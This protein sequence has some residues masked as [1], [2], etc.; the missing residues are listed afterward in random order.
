M[1]AEKE[2]GNLNYSLD[3]KL[4]KWWLEQNQLGCT[5]FDADLKAK[6]VELVNKFGE[7]SRTNIEHWLRNFKE[8]HEILQ[9]MPESS[10][11]FVQRNKRELNKAEAK[12]FVQDF[13]RRLEQENIIRDNIY[14]L[15][16]MTITC[17]HPSATKRENLKNDSLTFMLCTNATGNHKLP[18][19]CIYKYTHQKT[20]K[21]LK[22]TSP[23]VYKLQEN[24]FQNQ[25]I[26]IDWYCNY[27]IRSV[28]EHQWK[29]NISDIEDCIKISCEPWINLMPMDI[30]KFWKNLLEPD[31]HIKE[32]NVTEE[33]TAVEF[34]SKPL[35]LSIKEQDK[36]LLEPDFHTKEDNVTEEN[37]AVEFISKP[38]DLSIKEQD[39]NL[40]KP[41][42]HTK[43]DNVTEE[44]TAVEFISKL[45]DLSIKEQDKNLLEPDFYT[46]ED[47]V[48]EEDTAVELIS[49]P[50]DFSIKYKRLKQ[51]ENTVSTETVCIENAECIEENIEKKDNLAT[52]SHKL[53]K[54][55]IKN[56]DIHSDKISEVLASYAKAEA[57]GHQEQEGDIESIAE[58][59]CKRKFSGDLYDDV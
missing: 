38:L 29:T 55:I 15:I 50:L 21:I 1:Q 40:L 57:E 54:L 14:A 56:D 3:E 52:D 31:F 22:N 42:F 26:I 46:K 4:Y 28:K 49:K 6:M 23:L 27:F 33:D 39:K 35:D 16:D 36:N 51:Q 32:D 43:E 41:D 24:D 34:I 18:P 45:L 7:S 44:D 30:E 58:N 8:Q 13:T 25:E 19:F 20:P 5:T 47:N 53:Q 48:T 9:N 11:N 10:Q 17:K 2:Y 12:E 59:T 37:T